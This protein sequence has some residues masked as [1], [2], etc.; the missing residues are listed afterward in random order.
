MCVQ[1]NEDDKIHERL[2]QLHEP[3]LLYDQVICLVNEGK[4]VNIVYLNLRKALDTVSHSILLGKW[5]ALA[6]KGVLFA[7]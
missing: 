2:V 5:Q 3:D 6:W 4:A 1:E 7:R